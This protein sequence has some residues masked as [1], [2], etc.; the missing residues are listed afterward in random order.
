[1]SVSRKWCVTFA[2]AELGMQR[3]EYSNETDAKNSF[4]MLEYMMQVVRAETGSCQMRHLA[5]FERVS[6]TESKLLKRA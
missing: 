5:M 1:M 6:T 4:L 3:L 2:L